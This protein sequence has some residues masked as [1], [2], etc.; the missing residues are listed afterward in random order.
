MWQFFLVAAAGAVILSVAKNLAR[1]GT[2]TEILRCAQND[3]PCQDFLLRPTKGAA[4]GET[5]PFAGAHG[6]A[7]LGYSGHE[8]AEAAWGEA[9]SFES[10]QL[11]LFSRAGSPCHREVFA[12]ARGWP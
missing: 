9:A 11:S 5:T 2:S 8:K 10:V 1:T 4:E 3:R 12:R 6:R 7:T